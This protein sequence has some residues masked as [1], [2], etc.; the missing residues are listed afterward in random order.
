MPTVLRAAWLN[1]VF[2]VL[3][4]IVT[5][6]FI[7]V[8]V[9]YACV[10]TL[11]VRD[12]R[13]TLCLVRRILSY[14]GAAILRC[15]W[16]LVR[17]RFIDHAPGE[18]PPFVYVANHRSTSDAYLM[19]SLRGEFVQ[20]V[21]IWPFRIPVL[22][23][24]ARI[25]GYLSVREMPMESFLRKGTELLSQGVSVVAFPEGTRSGSQTMGPF[26]GSAF[27][28]AIHAGA[29]IAPLAI[30]G[31]ENI[32]RRGSLWLRP[33]RITIQKLPALDAAQYQTLGPFFLKNLA[34]EMIQRHLDRVEGGRP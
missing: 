13:K 14:Y 34:K 7:L 17:V 28:L 31:N 29:K 24:V 8:G 18:T 30:S 9:V 32:P 10:H 4:P 33:G 27:R 20:V 1:V 3:F 6:G 5:A 2:W 16:P 23:V 15:A 19:S 25:A 12:R 22:G 26:H 11:C 21:N